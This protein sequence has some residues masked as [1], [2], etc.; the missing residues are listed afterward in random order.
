MGN[1]IKK[2]K[3][4]IKEELK[5]LKKFNKSMDNILNNDPKNKNFTISKKNSIKDESD[6]QIKLIYTDFEKNRKRH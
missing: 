3:L 5:K 6:R 1:N 4:K 2:Y